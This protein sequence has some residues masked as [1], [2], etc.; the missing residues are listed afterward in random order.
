MTWGHTPKMKQSAQPPSF[1]C[2]LSYRVME[3]PVQDLCGHTFERRAIEAWIARGNQCCPISRKNLTPN[4]LTPNHLLAERIEKWKWEHE[5]EDLTVLK[6]NESHSTFPDDDDDNDGV[7]P[8]EVGIVIRDDGDIEMGGHVLPKTGFKKN[9]QQV[10]TGMTLLPQEREALEVIRKRNSLIKR[11][12]E[13]RKCLYCSCG[14]LMVLI[15]V[16]SLGVY[17]VLYRM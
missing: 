8:T 2:P 5:H 10:P 11:Y 1:V 6:L 7:G 3:E 4:N 9:Y 15:F 14:V 17:W 13:R 12:K 16:A